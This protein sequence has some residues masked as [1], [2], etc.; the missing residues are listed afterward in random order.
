MTSITINT[1]LDSILY[2]DTV[3]IPSRNSLNHHYVVGKLNFIAQNI[4][5]GIS[6]A[7]HQDAHFSRHPREATLNHPFG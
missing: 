6:F 4:H 7:V 1:P 3:G 2:P 5:P